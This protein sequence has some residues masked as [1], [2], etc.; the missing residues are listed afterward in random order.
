MGINRPA[1]ISTRALDPGKIVSLLA[2]Q[3][4]G[5]LNSL[6]GVTRIAPA[7]RRS[8]GEAWRLRRAEARRRDPE[9]RAHDILGVMRENL[10]AAG[11]AVVAPTTRSRSMRCMT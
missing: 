9:G 10:A 5:L 6:G 7:V 4:A 8:S 11:G 2:S 1:T 3:K